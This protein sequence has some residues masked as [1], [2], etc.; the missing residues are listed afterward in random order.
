MILG[1]SSTND[2]AMRV[3]GIVLV[4]PQP[5]AQD[6]TMIATLIGQPLQLS[7]VLALAEGQQTS[8]LICSCFRITDQQIHQA[9]E[10]EGCVSLNQL[11]QRLKCGTNCG[12]CVSEIRQLLNE[13][14]SLIMNKKVGV[15]S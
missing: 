5:I 4:S 7:S 6:Y 12:S 8:R 14:D 15:K 3:T 11:Q 10:Q 9:I 13:H 2:S 1:R